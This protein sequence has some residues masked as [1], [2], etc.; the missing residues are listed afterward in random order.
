MDLIK[1]GG[2]K[3]PVHFGWNTL[4]TFC[5]ATGRTLE[6]LGELTFDESIELIRCGLEEGCRKSGEVLQADKTDVC[7]WLD[8]DP[9]AY[10][11]IILLYGESL[12]K[13][14]APM[15]RGIKAMA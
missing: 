9:E 15:A 7:D 4:R 6:N 3:R 5:L 10:N 12:G 1:I 13:M 11:K 14:F 8:A 2:K